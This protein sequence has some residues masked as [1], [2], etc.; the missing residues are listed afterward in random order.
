MSLLAVEAVPPCPRCQTCVI[1]DLCKRSG[2]AA[3]SDRVG[4]AERSSDVAAFAHPTTRP[5]RALIRGDEHVLL[6]PVSL[7]LTDIFADL[8]VELRRRLPWSVFSELGR[9][10]RTDSRDQHELLFG[11]G[12]EIDRHKGLAVERLHLVGGELLV[13]QELVE[14]ERALERPVL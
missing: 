7:L 9:H 1:S 13:D 10:A 8:L 4:T 11:A 2:P 12:V 3:T 5:I 14:I 6:Q